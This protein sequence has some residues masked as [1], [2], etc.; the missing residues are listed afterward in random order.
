MR[1]LYTGKE[2]AGHFHSKFSA[3]VE[4]IDPDSGPVVFQG[5]HLFFDTEKTRGEQ[6][7]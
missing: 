6:K 1:S 5:D 2:L 7:L 3:V 4:T